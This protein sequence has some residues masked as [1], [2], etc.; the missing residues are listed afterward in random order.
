MAFL[1]PKILSGNTIDLSNVKGRLT[2]PAALPDSYQRKPPVEEP[3]LKDDRQ[4]SA[5][6][7][8]IKLNRKPW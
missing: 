5:S 7:S 6:K 2:T 4:K 8:K 1:R 3:K